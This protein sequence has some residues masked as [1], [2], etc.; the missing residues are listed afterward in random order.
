[1]TDEFTPQQLAL[2]H[3]QPNSQIWAKML[4]IAALFRASLIP[5]DVKNN[6]PATIDR[7]ITKSKANF[8]DNLCSLLSPKTIAYDFSNVE[9]NLYPRYQEPML[10]S[11]QLHVQ[12]SMSMIVSTFYFYIRQ[13]DG[14]P[15]VDVHSYSPIADF[16]GDVLAIEEVA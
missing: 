12:F 16:Y 10:L 14:Y 7:L 4:T 3:T 8:A 2:A 9:T 1:M 15:F 5:L 13:Q 11:L 6:S